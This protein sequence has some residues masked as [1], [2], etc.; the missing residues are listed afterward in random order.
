MN[1]NS[2]RTS[3][4]RPQAAEMTFLPLFQDLGVKTFPRDNPGVDLADPLTLAKIHSGQG[5]SDE[6]S[7][8]A[9]SFSYDAGASAG[10]LCI[11][12]CISCGVCDSLSLFRPG[13]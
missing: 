13:K 3:A 6:L 9:A 1:A 11:M 8:R 2:L 5:F 4:F 7:F 10:L 12:G